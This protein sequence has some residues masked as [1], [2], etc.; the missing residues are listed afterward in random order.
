MSRV[1]GLALL[2][3]ALI[4][5]LGTTSADSGKKKR[6]PTKIVASKVVGGGPSQPTVFTAKLVRKNG[7]PVAGVKLLF[8]FD[9]QVDD[10]ITNADGVATVQIVGCGKN[11][12]VESIR[13]PQYQKAGPKTRKVQPHPS[14]KAAG[15]NPP[16][17]P[18]KFV[19]RAKKGI[20]GGGL[21]APTTLSAQAY[22]RTRAG[23]VPVPGVVLY[24][25]WGNNRL[26]ASP[27]TGSDGWTS[28]T[29]TGCAGKY[30]VKRK[31]KGARVAEGRV[32]PPDS[33]IGFEGK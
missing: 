31:P 5:A 15:G 22:R 12:S 14:C 9:G 16:S 30:Y 27:P 33:C 26:K 21:E 24:F 2:M 23:E 17:K 10:E 32:N 8:R 29:M 25:K 6:V 28:V 13:T 3:A 4:I 19:V 1:R 11:Y 7:A 18:G 20:P